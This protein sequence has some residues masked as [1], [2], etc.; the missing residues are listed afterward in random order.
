MYNHVLKE[1]CGLR[2]P[3]T[4]HET[5]KSLNYEPFVLNVNKI[6][7]ALSNRCN[8]TLH[9]TFNAVYELAIHEK[10]TF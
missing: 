3:D 2:F 8:K 5:S 9:R 4:A 7:I 1:L 6:I 10:F